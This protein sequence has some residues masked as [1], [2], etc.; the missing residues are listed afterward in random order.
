MKKTVQHVF[1]II[2]RLV[3]IAIFLWLVLS[4]IEV[5]SHNL[6]T[7][8]YNYSE[9]NCFVILMKDFSPKF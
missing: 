5:I 1:S 7:E 6:D 9:W 2:F 8:P 4:Y 3:V